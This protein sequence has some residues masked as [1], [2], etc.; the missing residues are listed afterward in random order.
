MSINVEVIGGT[1]MVQRYV[2][3][4]ADRH[5]LVLD[6]ISDLFKIILSFPFP[7]R[8]VPVSE[9]SLSDALAQLDRELAAG[10][11]V[12]LHCRQGIG[13][14]RLVA[15]CPLITKGLDPETAVRRLSAARGAAVLET[16]EQRRWIDRYAESFATPRRATS[17]R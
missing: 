7:D 5:H 6:S 13:R 16:S 2:E 3:Q 12:V 8:E 15:A 14:T 10:R 11:N 1:P 4:V 17:R 9:S